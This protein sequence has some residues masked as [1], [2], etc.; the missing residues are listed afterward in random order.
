[1]REWDSNHRNPSEATSGVYYLASD[2]IGSVSVVT[3]SSGNIV[4]SAR[5]KP[6]G[7][8]ETT[9]AASPTDRT[10]TG[11]KSTD[12]GLMDYNARFYDP[13]VGKFI[14]PDNIIIHP[15]NPLSWDRYS[16][17]YN[18]PIIFA[19]PT[20]H[21]VD[22]SPWD[23]TCK[24]QVNLEKQL[25]QGT[26]P[27]EDS[28]DTVTLEYWGLQAWKAYLQFSTTA[29]WWNHNGFDI[30]SGD[31]FTLED[32]AKLVVSIELGAFSNKGVD[33]SEN[34][35]SYQ[36]ENGNSVGLKDAITHAGGHSYYMTCAFYSGGTCKGISRNG[37]LEWMGGMQV[38]R[39]AAKGISDSTRLALHDDDLGEAYVNGAL[40]PQKEWTIT[41]C[42]GIP[43][44]NI[45]NHPHSWANRSLM[46]D[47][48]KLLIGNATQGIGTNQFLYSSGLRSVVFVYNQSSR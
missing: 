28:S 6:Y 9:S 44:C 36:D 25:A 39:T 47:Q 24:N 8:P 20:G 23:K 45:G 27:P 1:M 14:N 46:N 33:Q 3:D 12:F 37:I 4:T 26:P 35:G 2:Q 30:Y 18:N 48:S 31:I 34:Y 19:D 40:S 5:Y 7:L 11:Q 13:I 21:D 15:T 29:G 32:A 10:Y 16:Y 43:G 22:C 38:A 42:T 17:V 41:D